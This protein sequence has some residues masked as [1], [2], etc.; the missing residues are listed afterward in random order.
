M[1][2]PD[3]MF[4]FNPWDIFLTSTWE[5]AHRK[6]LSPVE[7][8]SKGRTLPTGS[9]LH[10][11]QVSPAQ[12]PLFLFKG[13]WLV[14]S[15]SNQFRRVFKMGLQDFGLKIGNPDYFFSKNSHRLSL[16]SVLPESSAVSV[17]VSPYSNSRL[18]DSMELCREQK[19]TRES[20]HMSQTPSANR[21]C[22]NAHMQTDSQT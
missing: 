10:S 9:F 7:P 14:R 15:C 3:M 5:T 1:K 13:L 17:S 6:C 19:H 21:R 8:V 16:P 18:G 22:P 4:H 2:D 20:Q 12:P 11:S